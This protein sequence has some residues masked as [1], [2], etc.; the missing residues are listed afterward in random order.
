[1]EPIQTIMVGFGLTKNE[2]DFV[3]LQEVQSKEERVQALGKNFLEI[4]AAGLF[5]D[6]SLSESRRE[7]GGTWWGGASVFCVCVRVRCVRCVP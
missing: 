6:S 4:S 2:I 5:A 3:A 7:P 1:M